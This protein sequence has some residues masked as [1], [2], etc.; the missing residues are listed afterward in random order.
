MEV[1]IRDAD[2]QRL[3]EGRRGRIFVRGPTVMAGYLDQ[4]GATGAV[5]HDGWLD[6]GDLG[7]TAEGELYVHGRAKDLI[8]IRGANHPPEEFET[9]IESVAGVRSGRVAAAGFVPPG[10]DAEQLLL[11]V[12]RAGGENRAPRAELERE[13]RRA[14]RTRTGVEPHTVRIVAPGTLPRTSSGKLRRAEALARHLAGELSPPES[15]HPLALARHA[16]RSALGFARAR[17]AR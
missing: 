7:F 3:G 10:D 13:I 14:V 1:E 16:L 4:P 6:T 5:L 15:T 12:E 2:G 9:C 8:V 17:L 11:L